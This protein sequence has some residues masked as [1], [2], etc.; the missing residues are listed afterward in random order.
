MRLRIYL[1]QKTQMT[2][3][4]AWGSLAASILDRLCLV[5]HFHVVRF[6]YVLHFGSLA[7]TGFS[8]FMAATGQDM[9]AH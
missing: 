5:D 6:T 2:L 7:A 4:T 9:E 8:S 3:E 1:N